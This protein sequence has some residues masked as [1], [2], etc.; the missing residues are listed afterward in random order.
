MPATHKPVIRWLGPKGGLL[1][2]LL[3]AGLSLSACKTV[4]RAVF[5]TFAGETPGDRTP[6]V[7]IAGAQRL[8]R[9]PPAVPGTRFRPAIVP[10][11][12]PDGGSETLNAYRRVRQ[13]LSD[14]DDEFAFRMRSLKLYGATYLTAAEALDLSA[15]DPLPV[16][17]SAHKARMKAARDALDDID[18]DIGK[19]NKMIGLLQRDLTAVRAVQAA[20]RGRDSALTAAASA[21]VN[22]AT[23]LLAAAKKVAGDYV[24]YV[25]GQ[26][27]TLNRIDAQVARAKGADT[28]RTIQTRQT[29]FDE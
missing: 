25:S 9:V 27:D 11:A 1:T 4:D 22:T 10:D 8:G 24:V 28:V 18:G 14:R 15:G 3:V 20:A 17:D 13:A 6:F 29:L 2:V 7:E 5:L 12:G 16:N 26:R 19:L 23:R 21:S